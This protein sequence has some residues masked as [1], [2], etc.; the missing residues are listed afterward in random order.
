MIIGFQ[1]LSRKPM[2]KDIKKGA[3]P[4]VSFLILVTGAG[5]T[6]EANKLRNDSRQARIATPVLASIV[7]SFV[8]REQERQ[9]QYVFMSILI[10][11]FMP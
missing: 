10:L 3:N 11:C 7:T 8:T 5:D 4:F 2:F 6:F 9:A 1:Q